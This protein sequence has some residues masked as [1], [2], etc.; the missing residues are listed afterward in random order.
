MGLLEFGHSGA[1]IIAFPSSMGSFHEWEDQGMIRAMAHHLNAGHFQLICVGSVD[2]QSW[3]ANHKHPGARAWRQDEYDRY[4]LHEVLPFA[5]WR[6][7]HP[8]TIVTGASFGAYHA[9]SFGLRHPDRVNRILSMSGLCDISMFADGYSN[10]TVYF[11][12]PM[13][14]MT[15]EHDGWRLDQLRRQSI[16]LAVGNGDRLVHQNRELSGKLWAKGIGNALR[17]WDGFSHDWPWWH[18]MVNLYIGGAD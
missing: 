3:Y 6:N 17:E 16:I 15:H 7:N 12:N 18:K 13:A 1:T 11:H 14:F 2:Q 10:E 4:V 9:L 5:K 8:Y